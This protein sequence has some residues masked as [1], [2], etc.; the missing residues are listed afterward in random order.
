MRMLIRR[1]T[2]QEFPRLRWK[3]KKIQFRTP[4]DPQA[5]G[6]ARRR[7]RSEALQDAPFH[8]PPSSAPPF[9]PSSSPAVCSGNATLLT[10]LI[11]SISIATTVITTVTA[12]FFREEGSEMHPEDLAAIREIERS[13]LLTTADSEH[14]PRRILP[15]SSLGRMLLRHNTRWKLELLRRNTERCR[16]RRFPEPRLG[17]RSRLGCRRSS[18]SC[19][20]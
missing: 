12:A 14:S 4:R 17:R 6:W 13:E 11:H 5:S 10:F 7:S 3:S 16:L 1:R 8:P 18:R 2:D 20:G 9:S 15:V 19:R